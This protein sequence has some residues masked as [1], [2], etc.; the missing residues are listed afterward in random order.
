[1]QISAVSSNQYNQN[2]GGVTKKVHTFV[3]TVLFSTKGKYLGH[4][5]QKDNGDVLGRRMFSNG[6]TISYNTSYGSLFKEP[7]VPFEYH[8]PLG[9]GVYG[10]KH[11]VFALDKFKENMK[12]LTSLKG[13]KKYLADIENAPK[14]TRFTPC[15]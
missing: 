11:F 3:E 6:A 15:S 9:K 2:F 13:I 8:F 1:M 12:Q 4:H 7:Y 5:V 14:V 10:R